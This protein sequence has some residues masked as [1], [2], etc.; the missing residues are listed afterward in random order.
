[1]K[2]QT[3]LVVFGST[4]EH[5]FMHFSTVLPSPI[6]PSSPPHPRRN[7]VLPPIGVEVHVSRGCE[8]HGAV[9]PLEVVEEELPALKHQRTSD[10][11]R[12]G[13]R[14]GGIRESL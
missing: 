7:A 9:A 2:G 3:L 5:E 11:L 4:K 12:G 14:G 6:T 13:G 8:P 1:M 10:V